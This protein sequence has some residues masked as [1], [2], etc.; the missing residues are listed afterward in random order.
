V[1]GDVRF[2]PIAAASRD[3]ETEAIMTSI[4][5]KNLIQIKFCPNRCYISKA[6]L[7]RGVAQEGVWT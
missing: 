5:P 3:A 1:D 7:A 6:R 4:K 2:T